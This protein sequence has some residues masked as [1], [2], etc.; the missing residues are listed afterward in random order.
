MAKKYDNEIKYLPPIA[1]QAL[2]DETSTYDADIE[3]RKS[4]GFMKKL[5]QSGSKLNV[6]SLNP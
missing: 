6:S 4:I 5:L 3:I 2:L 1:V